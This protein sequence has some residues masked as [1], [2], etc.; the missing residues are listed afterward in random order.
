M[1]NRILISAFIVALGFFQS[2]HATAQSKARSG[3]R[4]GFNAS[5][6]YINDVNDRNPRYGFNAGFFT[7][8]PLV[9]PLYLQPEIA[10]ST[11]G[12]TAKYNIL[13]TFQGENTFK[14][15]YA[16]VPL[17]LTYKIGNVLDLH[18]G[19]YGAY[20]VNASTASKSDNGN[21][22]VVSLNEDN[23]NRFDYGL[24][25]G[26]SLYFGKFIIGTRYSHG[27]QKIA[28]SQNAQTYIGDSKNSVGQVNIGFCF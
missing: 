26:L 6:L 10:Y 1:K 28:N 22:S 12:T 9:G 5:N 11:K 14:L 24:T 15:D 3:I 7:Q 20:L 23:Y 19:A 8:I 16:E 18:A 17:M 4:G 25:A 13:N 21:S 27:L 2:N